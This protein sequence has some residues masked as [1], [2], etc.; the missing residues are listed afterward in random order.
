MH[1]QQFWNVANYAE[2]VLSNFGV[3]TKSTLVV[4]VGEANIEHSAQ[5]Y[6]AELALSF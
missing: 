5:T 3:G 4:V 1:L 2:E 6:N